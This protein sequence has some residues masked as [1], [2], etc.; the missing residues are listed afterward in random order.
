MKVKFKTITS[1]YWLPN[2][3]YLAIITSLIKGKVKNGDFIIISEKAICIAKNLLVDESKM[4]PTL[5]AKVLVTF[6]MRIVWAY[7]LGY[8]CRLKRRTIKRL[9]N[10]PIVEGSKHKQLVL[11][12]F[13]FMQALRHVSEGGIDVSNI[14]YS[15]AALPLKNAKE[16]AKKI[17]DEIKEK[18]GIQVNV[19]ITDTDMT[20]SFMNFHFT[21]R[22]YAIN[23]IITK[24]GVLAYIV[25]RFFKIKPRATPIGYCG[26]NITVEEALNLAHLAH[27]ARGYGAGR[28]PWDMAERF[29][30]N[31]TEVSWK[32]LCSIKHYPIVIVRKIKN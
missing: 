5:A 1:N 30:V 24:G 20:Y 12:H 7:F 25:G 4:K 29:G 26:E 19:M 23:G 14:A 6:W 31:L 27:N 21:P 13:G 17:K 2:S 9:R 3:N 32:M 18:L 11:Q 15:Y 10:Y 22:P 16:V 28:T 8:I